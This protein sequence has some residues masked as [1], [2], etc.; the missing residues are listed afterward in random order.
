MKKTFI[1]LSFGLITSVA[2]AEQQATDEAK[3]SE[4]TQEGSTLSE[5]ELTLRAVGE[6][7]AEES[8]ALEND[9]GS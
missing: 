2:F 4:E 8:A 3:V 7:L 1:Y 5:G 9:F 6:A